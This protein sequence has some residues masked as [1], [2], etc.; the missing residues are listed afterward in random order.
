MRALAVTLFALAIVGCEG[1]T[2][3]QQEENLIGGE[4]VARD[5]FAATVRLPASKC[6][7]SWVGPR[8]LLTAAHCVFDASRGAPM[9]GYAA[10]A[11]LAIDTA[12]GLF[13]VTI[14]VT[15][16]SETWAE[17]CPRTYC[18]IA[19]V[20]ARQDAADVALIVLRDDVP[21]QRFLPVTA[22]AQA[23]GDA[24]II[25]GFGCED[26]LY[27][28]DER[29]DINLASA[30]TRVV[31]ATD[32]LHEGSFIGEDHLEAASGNYFMTAGPAHAAGGA[33][34]CPGDSGGPVY[35]NTATGLAIA[36]VN[37][38]YTLLPEAQ[39][40]LGLPVTNWHTRLDGD[41]RHAIATWLG[42]HGATFAA[43]H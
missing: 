42:E 3:G 6:T 25:Q 5:L 21:D 36:G 2:E 38:N 16:V 8:H 18:G 31:P 28:G 10:G 34:L 11:S 24:V 29:S 20:A 13:D 1:P 35:A 27:A 12:T 39:D 4:R 19:E 9:A 15:V 37:A 43:R 26:G 22:D 41:A 40:P 14:E 17:L 23:P 32:A 30:E 7:A 33:G